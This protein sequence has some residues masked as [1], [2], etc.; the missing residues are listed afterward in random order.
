MG[1]FKVLD[2]ESGESSENRSARYFD[3]LTWG[4]I[5]SP[6]KLSIREKD[7]RKR[8]NFGL[9]WK[10]HTFVNCVVIEKDDPSLY[11]TACRL[12][13][14]DWVLAAG[15]LREYTYTPEKGKRAGQPVVGQDAKIEY[16]IPQRAVA[17]ILDSMYSGELPTLEE[18]VA[19][20]DPELEDE[21]EW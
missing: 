8:V 18:N 3:M 21:P 10:K 1:Q 2:R 17:A 6:P 12:K 5:Y 11:D 20:F 13:L 7:G 15:R 14:G 4:E 16:L 9:R 19:E